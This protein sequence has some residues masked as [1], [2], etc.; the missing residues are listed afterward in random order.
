MVA[1][2]ASSVVVMIVIIIILTIII[3][4]K[5]HHRVS[6]NGRSRPRTLKKREANNGSS[7]D[8][9]IEPPSPAYD[10]I[11]SFSERLRQEQEG[12]TTNCN[13]AYGVTSKGR[14]PNIGCSDDTN[15]QNTGEPLTLPEPKDATQTTIEDDSESM[16]DDAEYISDVNTW[17]GVVEATDLQD[18]LRDYQNVLPPDHLFGEYVQ[19]EFYRPSSASG[20]RPHMRTV[21]YAELQSFTGNKGMTTSRSLPDIL[22]HLTKDNK[23]NHDVHEQ[24]GGRIKISLPST[25]STNFTLV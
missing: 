14:P 24:N 6:S 10:D 1:A 5:V 19:P 7:T 17:I 11:L 23:N 3:L 25:N 13:Q 9:I 4:H 12:I 8:N 22:A 16:Q 2:I 18:E 15:Q 20:V 21:D